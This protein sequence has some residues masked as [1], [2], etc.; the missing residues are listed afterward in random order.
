MGLPVSH[1]YQKVNDVI[2]RP[3]TNMKPG[4]TSMTVKGSIAMQEGNYHRETHQGHS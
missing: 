2:K 3:K 4:F 1:S